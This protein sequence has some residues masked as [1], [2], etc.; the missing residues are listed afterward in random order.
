M[1]CQKRQRI[2][3]KGEATN[4]IPANCTPARAIADFAGP[5]HQQFADFAG[6]EKKD[7]R[8]F[9]KKGSAMG[10]YGS[11]RWEAHTKAQ[12]VDGLARLEMSSQVAGTIRS[13]GGRYRLVANAQP[14]Q[15]GLAALLGALER[16]T[17]WEY[18]I[19]EGGAAIVIDHGGSGRPVRER[20]AIARR[21][22]RYGLRLYWLCPGCNARAAILYRQRQ[23]WRCRRCHGLT[24]RSCQQ[25]DQRVTDM[26]RAGLVDPEN[27]TLPTG[28][29]GLVTAMRDSLLLLKAHQIVTKRYERAMKR[30]K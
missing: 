26:I 12:T 5:E 10:G 25:S 22:L 11:T 1:T 3:Q 4:G 15:P 8:R 9:M 16:H 2:A 7:A 23:R 19:V 24:Y 28:G 20:V 14:S 30:I 6:P 21:A 29:G 27:I 17:R 13:G 18:E